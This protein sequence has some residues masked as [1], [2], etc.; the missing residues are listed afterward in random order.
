MWLVAGGIKKSRQSLW[1][2]F[3][4]FNLQLEEE[5]IMDGSFQSSDLRDFCQPLVETYSFSNTL[6]TYI[7]GNDH[8]HTP[9]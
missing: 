1:R 8:S 2:D 5:S 9:A 7:E 3:L 6:L 4:V